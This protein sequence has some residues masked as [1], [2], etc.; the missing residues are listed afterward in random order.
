MKSAESAAA[1]AISPLLLVVYCYVLLHLTLPLLFSTPSASSVAC[2]LT[3]SSGS[4]SSSS[5]LN[6]ADT[7][8]TAAIQN[9]LQQ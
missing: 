5:S 3:P 4:S 7:T 6:V 2:E 8:G 9:G 1:A